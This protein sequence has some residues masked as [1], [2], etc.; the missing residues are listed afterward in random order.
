MPELSHPA[1]HRSYASFTT[2][3]LSFSAIVVV[4]V[5]CESC[6]EN[7]WESCKVASREKREN[8][9]FTIFNGFFFRSR[10]EKFHYILYSTQ[11]YDSRS[12]R[13]NMC[14]AIQCSFV[15]I[16]QNYSQT[17]SCCL[18]SM[19]TVI[20]LLDSVFFA[21]YTTTSKLILP[22]FFSQFNKRAAAS[23]F[24]AFV[25]FF[26]QC[27]LFDTRPFLRCLLNSE[28]CES[29]VFFPLT[30]IMFAIQQNLQQNE[31]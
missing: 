30:T 28:Y 11:Q 3:Q 14:I 15:S 6:K 19:A 8:R 21:N 10:V 2:A 17:T 12:P 29:T 24:F 4:G 23:F 31:I 22:L 18:C 25:N 9:N 20:T 13:G 26:M 7:P 27:L 1:Q 5:V 16:T